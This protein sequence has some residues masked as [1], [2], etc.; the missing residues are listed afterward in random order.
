MPGAMQQIALYQSERIDFVAPAQLHDQADCRERPLA[1]DHDRSVRPQSAI[2]SARITT[3]STRW[4]PCRRM[5]DGW[6]K[7]GTRQRNR[8]VAH[9]LA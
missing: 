3:A 9:P 5:L 2:G 4:F 7:S 6:I 8:S 1:S